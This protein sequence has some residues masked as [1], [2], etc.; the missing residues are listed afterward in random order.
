MGW[1]DDEWLEWRTGIAAS[2]K[3]PPERSLS[4][5]LTMRSVICKWSNSWPRDFSDAGCSKEGKQPLIR[6]DVSC[7]A[8]DCNTFADVAYI[9]SSAKCPLMYRIKSL[10]RISYGN[11]FFILA[12]AAL[13]AA[14][15]LI[16][17]LRLSGR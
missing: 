1:W 11:S 7:P 8:L 10:A 9:S 14:A 2:V 6:H 4:G 13:A 3:Q 17:I 12:L 5:R 16:V 15:I